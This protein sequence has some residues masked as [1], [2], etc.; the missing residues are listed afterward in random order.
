MKKFVL[1]IL[2]NIIFLV[3][4]SYRNIEKKNLENFSK[5]NKI[6]R[7]LNESATNNSTNSTTNNSTNSTTNNS[8][9][10][11]TNNSTD[12]TTNNSTNSTTDNSTN[13]TTDNSTN[14]TTNNSTNSTTNNSTNSTTDNSTDS[15]TDNSTDSTTDNSTDS[16][17]DNSTD[18]TGSSNSTDPES[19]LEDELLLGYDNFERDSNNNINFFA[20][21]RYYVYTT[22]RKFIILILTS[23]G[24]LRAL[25]ENSQRL[26]CSRLSNNSYVHQYSCHATNVTGSN[27]KVSS[28]EGIEQSY[29]A[30]QPL[31]EQTGD[32]FKNGLILIS[33]CHIDTINNQVIIQGK[34][35]ESLNSTET[36]LNIQNNDDTVIEVPSSISVYNNDVEIKLNPK[37]KI[38][39]NLDRTIG[40]NKDGSS[41]M[42]LFP[43]STEA[44]LQYPPFSSKKYQKKS[45]GGLSAGGIVAII[46]PCI[47]V[48]LAI[49]AIAYFIGN[50]PA[51]PAIDKNFGSNTIGVNS[52]TNV[53]H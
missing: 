2:I 18:S 24:N 46:L 27:I 53:V 36:T 44:A 49:T 8:T 39:A 4:A 14:S 11:T 34:K 21:V 45:S 25:E 23:T 42:L 47:A 6:K 12:S 19:L 48:L 28:A 37:R 38:D 43:N 7:K 52:S 50:K 10:S 16:T 40:S 29:L 30:E 17:T 26:N 13:S 33:D 35:T 32:I 5:Y 22:I 41:L 20:Y 15:T 1:F 9:N 51:V 3:N 31:E